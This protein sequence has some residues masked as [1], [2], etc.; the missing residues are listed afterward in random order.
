MVGD[1]IWLVPPPGLVA[2]AVRLP[3]PA[4]AGDPAGRLAA[5]LAA[6]AAG[7]YAWALDGPE[8][9]RRVWGEQAQL[10][11]A[12]VEARLDTLAATPSGSRSAARSRPWPSGPGW[13]ASR[14]AAA[15]PT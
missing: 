5:L 15:G 11:L 10:G 1:A 14:P 4:P 7:A 3:R 12:L 2:A 8:A 9:G 13:P 6:G